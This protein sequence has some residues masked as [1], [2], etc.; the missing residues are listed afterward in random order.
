VG[1]QLVELVGREQ[2]LRCPRAVSTWIGTP[3]WW[4]PP[5]RPASSKVRR[6]EITAPVART[7]A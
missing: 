4:S 6:P 2:C 5:Q 7:S 3:S 1:L